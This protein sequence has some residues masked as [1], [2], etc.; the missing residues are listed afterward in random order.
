MLK[1]NS[2]NFRDRIAFGAPS[3]GSSG[4]IAEDDILTTIYLDSVG[5]SYPSGYPE[6]G[7]DGSGGGANIVLAGGDLGTGGGGN[8]NVT[9]NP[10]HYVLD[11]SQEY[12]ENTLTTNGT[13]TVNPPITLETVGDYISDSTASIEAIYTAQES[14]IKSLNLDQTGMSSAQVESEIR[15]MQRAETA[16]EGLF[17]N[18]AIME[19]FEL[20]PGMF[21][22]LTT[23]LQIPDTHFE[24]RALVEQGYTVAEAHMI[25]NGHGLDEAVLSDAVGNFAELA[26]LDEQ[27]ILYSSGIDVTGGL[28]IIDPNTDRLPTFAVQVPVGNASIEAYDSGSSLY[29][30]YVSSVSVPLGYSALR[31]ADGLEALEAALIANPT[32]G[33]DDDATIN[34]TINDVGNLMPLDG[35]DNF[36]FS[37]SLKTQIQINPI[38]WSTIQ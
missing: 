35:D 4:S 23:A 14:P 25:A 32:P 28:M 27:G 12:I 8:G 1:L 13:V 3:E 26:I 15:M 22:D 5:T 6:G 37:L 38:L 20:Y 34:G 2:I 17:Y 36:V 30:D 18:W 9:L 16:S 19:R 29:H 10:G 24:A 33:N 11:L 7:P 21:A 31:G